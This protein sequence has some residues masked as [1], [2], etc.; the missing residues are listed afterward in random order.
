MVDLPKM[1]LEQTYKSIELSKKWRTFKTHKVNPM[2]SYFDQIDMMMSDATYGQYW[3]RAQQEDSNYLNKLFV[4]EIKYRCDH[5]LNVVISISGEQGT[6]K[7]EKIG[8]KVLMADGK[9]KKIEDIKNGEKVIS[10]QENGN[11]TFEKVIN[12]NKWFCKEM[13]AI[14]SK[15]NNKLLYEVSY[16]HLIPVIFDFKWFEKGKTHKTRKSYFTQ[17]NLLMTP[18]ELIEIQNKIRDTRFQ[19]KQGAFIPYFKNKKDCNIDA[20]SLGV[21]LGD[22]YFGHKQFFITTSY[23]ELIFSVVAGSGNFNH[24]SE[25][26]NNK[27][28][29]Y[30]WLFNSSFPQKIK[31]H[32]LYSKKAGEK[33][34]PKSALLSSA[35]YRASLL[36]GLIDTDGYINKKGRIETSTKSKQLAEDIS[37]LVYSLGGNSIIRKIFKKCQNFESNWYYNV[38]INLG[39]YTSLL[40]LKNPFKAKRILL[41][42]WYKQGIQFK[43]ERSEPSEVV[44]IIITGD[45]Q[46][47]ITD[48]FCI[49]HNSLSGIY[50]A[51]LLGKIYGVP[52][53][54]NKIAFYPEELDNLIE[55]SNNRETFVMDEQQTANVGVMSHTIKQRLVDYEEQLRAEMINLVY[56]APSVRDHAHYFVL[57]A[58]NPIRITNSIC[59][60]CKKSSCEGCKM[61]EW[62]RSGYPKAFKLLLSTKKLTDDMLVPRGYLEIPMPNY[63]IAQ[64]YDMIKN[65]HTA[66]LKKKES[67][68]WN[69]MQKLADVLFEKH[70]DKILIKT[71]K[72]I[73]K[74]ASSKNLE[75]IIYDEHGMR[76]F[77]KDGLA[78]FITLL[79]QKA[80]G[81]IEKKELNKNEDDE[82]GLEN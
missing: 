49:T 76:Y 82:N 42:K 78:L 35:K 37:F 71:K 22:G 68:M 24:C 4:E 33:F 13:Y 16:N 62:K 69:N 72:G 53:S 75:I 9:W 5:R 30:S 31:K 21:F 73:Y 7:C 74:S 39:A 66:E 18:K 27:A 80:Q 25:K 45:S 23:P 47:Y 20:Y 60:K 59:Q 57:K 58:E 6:G 79:K 11:I 26:K 34:I 50:L 65:K 52:F 81:Y 3:Q 77:T 12:K 15:R 10:L 32:G 51:L 43:V 19:T 17:L 8:S 61:P 64:E 36:S 56:V 1:P 46:L 2:K 40:S 48:N 38:S 54:I 63:A 14:K 28:K 55:N 41:Q 67:M 29:K 44:G 70:K